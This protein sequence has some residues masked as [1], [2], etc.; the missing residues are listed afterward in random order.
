[1]ELAQQVKHVHGH[2]LALD[3]RLHLRVRLLEGQS[4]KLLQKL[5]ER[6]SL[7][8]QLAKNLGLASQQG[9][10]L[11]HVEH[12]SKGCLHHGDVLGRQLLKVFF[13]LALVKE[14]LFQEQTRQCGRLSVF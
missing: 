10:W 12:L 1:M 3:N 2:F 4:E 7:L 14:K 8:V 5:R 13:R 11:L 6:L 9:H